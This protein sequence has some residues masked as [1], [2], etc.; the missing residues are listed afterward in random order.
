MSNFM[1]EE[2]QPTGEGGGSDR[3]S[4]MEG[5]V[6]LCREVFGLNCDPFPPN[7]LKF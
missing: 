4:W 3:W 2:N 6:H 1:T 5:N 7:M